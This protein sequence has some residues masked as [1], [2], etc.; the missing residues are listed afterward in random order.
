MVQVIIL[1][2]KLATN[3]SFQR[4]NKSNQDIR[5]RPINPLVSLYLWLKRI[6]ISPQKK[7]KL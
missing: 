5:L 7:A 6:Y 1:K 3:L 4:F 2:E